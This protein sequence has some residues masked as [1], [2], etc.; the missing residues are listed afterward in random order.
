[1]PRAAIQ[2]DARVQANNAVVEEYRPL[3]LPTKEQA[4][5]CSMLAFHRCRPDSRNV[6]QFV[7]Y[8]AGTKKGFSYYIS[9]RTKSKAPVLDTT[10]G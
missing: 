9:D 8:L 2:V 5:G 7:G 10:V 4:S 3:I 1:M 6:S